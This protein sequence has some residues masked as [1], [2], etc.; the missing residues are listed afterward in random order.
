MLGQQDIKTTMLYT[1]VADADTASA[2]MKLP[3]FKTPLQ[4]PPAES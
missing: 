3:S 4:A 2:V 1:K